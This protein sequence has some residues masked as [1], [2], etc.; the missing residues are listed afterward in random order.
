MQNGRSL[1]LR[2]NDRGPYAKSRIIDVSKRAAQLLGFQ[3]QGTTKVRVEVMEKESKALKAAL[4]GQKTTP[5]RTANA[6]VRKETKPLQRAQSYQKGSYFVQVGSF[7]RESSA[8]DAAVVVGN[9]SNIY[10]VNVNGKNY[11]RVRMGPFAARSEAET[12]LSQMQSKGVYDAKIV[13]D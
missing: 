13:T 9:G 11:Y 1:V 8:Q 4:T 2:V 7:S 5:V 12:A 6:V 3:A 10:Y